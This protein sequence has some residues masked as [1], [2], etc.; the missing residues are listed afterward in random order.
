MGER[1]AH[2]LGKANSVHSNDACS[3]ISESKRDSK[4]V[5]CQDS[6]N[7]KTQPTQNAPSHTHTR[8]LKYPIPHKTTHVCTQGRTHA[9]AHRHGQT[10]THSHTHT[11]TRG[12]AHMRTHTHTPTHAQTQARIYTPAPPPLH[13]YTH[14]K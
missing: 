6:T 13:T 5:I 7:N 8:K 12:Q 3:R 14:V 9:Y 2:I 4:K 10:H 1:R 11:H